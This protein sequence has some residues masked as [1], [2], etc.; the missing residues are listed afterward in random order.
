MD[1]KN[2]L[3]TRAVVDTYDNFK[4]NMKEYRMTSEYQE[5]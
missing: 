3:T 2:N 4:K 5:V 1:L